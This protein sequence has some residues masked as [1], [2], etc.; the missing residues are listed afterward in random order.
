MGPSFDAWEILP[1]KKEFFESDVLV[2]QESTLP[3]WLFQL[4]DSESLHDISIHFCVS[5]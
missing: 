3:K 2:P 1:A 5:P 4:D